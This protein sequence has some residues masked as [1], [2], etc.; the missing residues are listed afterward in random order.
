MLLAFGGRAMILQAVSSVSG[1]VFSYNF[2]NLSSAESAADSQYKSEY[3]SAL[4]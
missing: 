2:E 3:Y 4:M 1:A